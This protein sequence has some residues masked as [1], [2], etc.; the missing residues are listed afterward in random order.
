ME[1]ETW[2]LADLSYY[3]SRYKQ[4]LQ[5]YL[6]STPP[7]KP[8]DP[9]ATEGYG[10]MVR[11][12]L[13]DG[14]GVEMVVIGKKHYFKHPIYQVDSEGAIIGQSKYGYHRGPHA[15]LYLALLAGAE[16]VI[17]Q[18][19]QENTDKW[20]QWAERVL[21]ESIDRDKDSP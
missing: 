17:A 21:K 1:P 18:H 2:T 20:D 15:E 12:I 5:P 16:W 13:R 9:I 14:Y 4:E 11:L 7:A 6:A 19:R 8:F 10:S 3:L